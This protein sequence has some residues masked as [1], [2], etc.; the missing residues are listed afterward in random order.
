MIFNTD[1]FF[2][3]KNRF[4]GAHQTS[5][6]WAINLSFSK[7]LFSTDHRGLEDVHSGAE[8]FEVLQGTFLLIE[9]LGVNS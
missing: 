3:I 6:Y 2:S 9:V 8:T 1:A 5:H 7:G 4:S